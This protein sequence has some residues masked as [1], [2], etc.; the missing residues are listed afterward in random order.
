MKLPPEVS[1]EY[2]FKGR[3][4]ETASG[5]RLHY[6]DEGKGEGTPVL[7]LH[8]NPSWSFLYRNLVL[9]LRED[10]RC[11]VPDHLG[12]G[13]SD[14]PASARTKAPVPDPRSVTL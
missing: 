12:C 2:P 9:A 11:L 5:A 6:L 7:M 3:F 14:K 8:G 13:L 10:N 4:V 1:A